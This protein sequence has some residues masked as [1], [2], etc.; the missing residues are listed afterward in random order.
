MH[1]EKDVDETTAITM[2]R[3]APTAATFSNGSAS[4]MN[5]I[6]LI[7]TL[8]YFWI[9]SRQIPVVIIILCA[10]NMLLFSLP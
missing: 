3:L 4:T 5:L 9:I 8:C 1:P 2:V 7:T 10:K 6:N